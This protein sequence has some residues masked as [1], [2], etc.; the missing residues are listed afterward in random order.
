MNEMIG[1]YKITVKKKKGNFF[2]VLDFGG[3]M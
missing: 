1:F 2:F 3:A